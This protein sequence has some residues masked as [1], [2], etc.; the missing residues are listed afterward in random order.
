M[1]TIELGRAVTLQSRLE[2]A[3]RSTIERS[4]K[5]AISKVFSDLKYGTNET[6]LLNRGLCMDVIRIITSFLKP[7]GYREPRI[8]RVIPNCRSCNMAI[9]DILGIYA[10]T[11]PHERRTIEKRHFRYILDRVNKSTLVCDA[12]RALLLKL[13]DKTGYSAA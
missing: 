11:Q 5:T 13:V 3:G 1:A 7:R 4:Q 9:N 10:Y 12:D 8:C 6:I 2:T